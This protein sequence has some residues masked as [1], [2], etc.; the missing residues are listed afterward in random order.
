MRHVPPDRFQTNAVFYVT[1]AALDRKPVFGGA[2]A[3]RVLLD[4]LLFFCRRKEIEVV[5]YVVM[6]DHLHV[7]L[8]LRPPLTLPNW[9]RRFKTFTTHALGGQPI[10]Q[11]G[12]WSE[13][14]VYEKFAK[15]KLSY[16]HD[17]PVR[18]GLTTNAVLFPSSSAKEYHEDTFQMVTPYWALDMESGRVS[19]D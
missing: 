7:M 17:N 4:S 6:P 9:A 18:S 15:E 3:I 11:A 14:V 8:R 13:S 16:M 1:M 5:G 19:P 12:Y 10:W 2:L